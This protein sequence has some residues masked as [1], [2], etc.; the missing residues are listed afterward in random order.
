M[1][2]PFLIE[3]RT[4]LRNSD[5][6]WKA[7]LV[8]FVLSTHMDSDGGSCFPAV[9]TVGRE[10]SMSERSVQAG[11]RELERAGLVVTGQRGGRHHGGGYA[12][13][14]YRARLPEV[15]VVH[16]YDASGAGAAGRGAR[17]GL[18][19]AQLVHP[20]TFLED[21][22]ESDSSNGAHSAPMRCS[23]AGCDELAE[24]SDVDGAW[25]KEHEHIPF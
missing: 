7:K 25:C 16:R 24:F 6:T 22:H 12:S 15:K 21:A 11:L 1:N 13:N 2:R 9:P 14:T 3:W 5:L 10:A 23:E 4:A 8:G 20:R 17:D 19:V 18:P